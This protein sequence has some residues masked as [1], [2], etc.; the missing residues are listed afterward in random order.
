MSAPSRPPHRS[1]HGP[2]SVADRAP[3]AAAPPSLVTARAQDA[4]ERARH[5]TWVG[6]GALKLLAAV[7]AFGLA[8]ELPWKHA[9]DIGASTGGFTE[10]LLH[11]GAARV[12]A[13]DVGYDQMVDALRNDRR[14]E[15]LERVNFKTVSLTVAPGPYD[16]FVSD[17]SFMAA[18]TLLKPLRKRIRPGTR[19]VM[20]VKPQFELPDALLPPGGVVESRNL[21]KFAF[22][23]FKRK[24]VELGFRI[25]QRID[26]PIA[27]GEGNVEFLVLLEFVGIPEAGATADT[28]VESDAEDRTTATAEQAA[29][30]PTGP[31]SRTQR[32]ER[33]TAAAANAAPVAP[34]TSGE[35]TRPAPAKPATRWTGPPKP[36]PKKRR[37]V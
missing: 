14:V 29:A 22:N 15:L 24:A 6:R 27:G 30:L 23:R 19:G 4:L 20:L 32:P 25:I 34:A 11:F 28:E 1:A 31:T 35:A 21:R 17:V 37:R 8:T 3:G 33:A 16:F 5:R 36:N 12:T 13:V 18:R 9:I 7:E 26:C 10:V 2:R